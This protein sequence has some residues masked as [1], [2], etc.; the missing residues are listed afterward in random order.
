M[1]RVL[2]SKYVGNPQGTMQYFEAGKHR[3]LVPPLGVKIPG[4]GMFA[5]DW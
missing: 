2:F 5:R 4:E 3:A 1:I